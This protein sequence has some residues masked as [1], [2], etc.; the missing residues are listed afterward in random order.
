M[1]EARNSESGLAKSGNQEPDHDDDSAMSPTMRRLILSY[2]NAD[3]EQT[4]D[5]GAYARPSVS[6]RMR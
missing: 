6:R 1:K 4:W 2:V 5:T 3:S